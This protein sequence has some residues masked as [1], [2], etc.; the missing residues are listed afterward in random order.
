MPGVGGAGAEVPSRGC[1]LRLAPPTPRPVREGVLP[2]T[3]D[4]PNPACPKN[5]EKWGTLKA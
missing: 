1:W 4:I 3:G 2:R 5:K